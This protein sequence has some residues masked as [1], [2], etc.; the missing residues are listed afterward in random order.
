[1]FDERR[2][3]EHIEFLQLLRLTGDFYGKPFELLPWQRE[4]IANVY[5]TLTDDGRRQ[6]KYAYLELPKKNGKALAL[7]T[8]IPTPAGWTTMGEIREGDE[9]FDA[10]GKPC[11]VSFATDVMRGRPCYDVVFS[12]GSVICA[13]AEHNWLTNAWVDTPG[14]SNKAKTR[15]GAVRYRGSIARV[16][17]T[18][19]IRRTLKAGATNN[20]SVNVAGALMLP[21]SNLPIHAGRMARRWSVGKCVNY[22]L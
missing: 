21:T 8:P 1:V 7:D 20:H 3:N 18:E 22:V 5:G 16:R 17:T 11:R 19:E 10:D 14:G 2:A 13:D 12:D 6:Y 4:I 9:V 15:D